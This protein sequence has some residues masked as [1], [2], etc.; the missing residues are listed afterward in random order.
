MTTKSNPGRPRLMR[1]G[2][3]VNVYLSADALA[4]ASRLGGGNV[5]AGIRQAL[6][7]QVFIGPSVRPAN[8]PLSK[9]KPIIKFVDGIVDGSGFYPVDIEEKMREKIK[10]IREDMEALTI[11]TYK[12]GTK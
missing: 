8:V 11:Q 12:D 4:E 3:R 5:S 7:R 6:Q 2:R 1:D 10:E 9:E